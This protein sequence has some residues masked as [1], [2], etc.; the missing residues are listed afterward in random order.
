MEF[1]GMTSPTR[2]ELLRMVFVL[3]DSAL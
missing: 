3:P 1:L 2:S